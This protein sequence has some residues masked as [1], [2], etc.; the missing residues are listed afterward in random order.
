MVFNF[1]IIIVSIVI[2]AIPG[3]RKI[4]NWIPKSVFHPRTSAIILIVDFVVMAI[5]PMVLL[6][7]SDS[8]FLQGDLSVSRQLYQAGMA[9]LAVNWVT[10]ISV[11][12]I[13]FGIFRSAATERIRNVKDRAD[14]TLVMTVTKVSTTQ[15][16]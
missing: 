2:S 10:F 12:A 13:F 9:Y 8:L 1:I 14:S 15:K 7:L 3:L 5:P 16:Q 6:P 4:P 11:F